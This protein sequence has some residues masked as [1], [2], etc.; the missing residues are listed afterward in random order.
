M[1][2]LNMLRNIVPCRTYAPN[3]ERLAM[4]EP[5]TGPDGGSFDESWSRS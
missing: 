1:W 4:I 5:G 3:V 2:Y